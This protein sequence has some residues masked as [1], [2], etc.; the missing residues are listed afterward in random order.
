[1]TRTEDARREREQLARR[2]LDAILRLR[3]EHRPIYQGT[4]FAMIGLGRHEEDR[5]EGPNAKARRRLYLD[6]KADEFKLGFVHDNAMFD[7][8]G[9][10][11]RGA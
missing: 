5:G 9:A 8:V 11:R 2:A 7:V 10:A 4:L 6:L 1:V 3:G